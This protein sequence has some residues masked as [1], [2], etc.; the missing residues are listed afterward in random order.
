M[1][2]NGAAQEDL[3]NE[4]AGASEEDI[5]SQADATDAAV[6]DGTAQIEELKA[7]VANL[8]D[9]ILRARAETENVRRRAEKDK[10]DASAYAATGFARD[11]LVVLDNMRRAMDA[12]PEEVPSEFNALI[13][14]I[15]L[16][17]RE[18]TN[19]LARH[20]IEEISPAQGDKFDPKFHQAMFEVPTGEQEPGT[21]VHVVNA[22]FKIKDRL[23]RAAMVG[24]AKAAEGAPAVDTEA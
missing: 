17:A 21:V 9:Q 23:L 11:M 4:E 19:T 16:T 14:G 2:D 1:T 7:E 6:D 20:N 8:K 24:V 10:A 13:E 5:A 18:L 12:K 22:G 15:D 3:P